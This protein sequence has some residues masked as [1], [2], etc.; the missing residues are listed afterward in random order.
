[1]TD[2]KKESLEDFHMCDTWVA[3]NGL[4]ENSIGQLVESYSQAESTGGGLVIGKVEVDE[5]LQD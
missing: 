2:K 1:V 3:D 5:E 4:S